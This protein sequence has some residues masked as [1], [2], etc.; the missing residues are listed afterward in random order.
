MAAMGG[1]AVAGG[2]TGAL[3]G[4]AVALGE[5]AG[6]AEGVAL[7]ESSMAKGLPDPKARSPSLNMTF[8]VSMIRLVDGLRMR[9]AGEKS[10]LPT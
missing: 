8:L 5:G 4:C 7:T 10:A 6:G 2:F 9:N 3:E 1:S